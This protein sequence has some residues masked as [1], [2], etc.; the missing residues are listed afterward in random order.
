MAFKPKG[1]HYRIKSWVWSLLRTHPCF[2]TGHSLSWQ[3]RLGWAPCS[4]ITG[5]VN[6]IQGGEFHVCLYF[7][8]KALITC[9]HTH[10]HTCARVQQAYKHRAWILLSV[11]YQYILRVLQVSSVWANIV[12]HNVAIYTIT[13]IRQ[14]SLHKARSVNA[15]R[16]S[17]F[18][19]Y[20][21][22]YFVSLQMCWTYF[23]DVC[24]C[25][26]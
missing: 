4:G 24:C 7:G 16:Q 22:C 13:F 18:V 15:H 19:H 14:L 11:I 1:F 6:L 8:V 5:S 20:C 10:T 21:A 2:L 17:V 3:L 25:W 26:V 9:T 23:D 12:L